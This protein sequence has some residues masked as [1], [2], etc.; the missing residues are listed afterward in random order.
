[1]SSSSDRHLIDASSE[2]TNLQPEESNISIT[3][4][5]I[6]TSIEEILTFTQLIDKY[7]EDSMFNTLLLDDSSMV[8]APTC[9]STNNDDA[10]LTHPPTANYTLSI[11]ENIDSRITQNSRTYLERVFP[12]NRMVQQIVC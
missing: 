1:M 11:T 7:N 4:K 2:E 6:L 3:V 5:G 9:L 8:S 10:M 12:R